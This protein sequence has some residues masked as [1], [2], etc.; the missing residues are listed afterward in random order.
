MALTALGGVDLPPHRP[1]AFDHGDVHLAS[2][3]VFVAHTAA[4]KSAGVSGVAG[5]G[6]IAGSQRAPVDNATAGATTTIIDR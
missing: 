2:G 3:R 6:A 1:S 5:N 4:G